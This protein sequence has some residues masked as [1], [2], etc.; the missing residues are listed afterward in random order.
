MKKLLVVLMS[1]VAL[2][3]NAAII[4][5]DSF[6]SI[7]PSVIS[8]TTG[9]I[10]STPSSEF[11]DGGALHF[12]VTGDRFANTV[13]FD[14]SSGGQVSFAFKLG[15]TLD[16]RTFEQVDGGENID[17]NYSLDNGSSW[18]NLAN[19]GPTTT[20][21]VDTWGTFSYVLQ[22]P[23]ISSSVQFQWIQNSHSGTTFD[24]WAVDN[25]VV[26]SNAASVSA[27]AGLA[28]LGLGLLGLAAFG[29]KSKV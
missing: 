12:N 19:F 27:P 21:F 25:F 20:A 11:L 15:G 5:N 9:S 6:D 3:A 26:N 18:L 2:N 29:R 14:L 10:V 23:V 16:T 8:S 28:F 22:A 13:N 4:A 1:A 7:D 17:F 24:N